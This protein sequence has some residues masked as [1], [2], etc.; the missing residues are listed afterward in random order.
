M[1]KNE[2]FYPFDSF[3]LPEDIL[4][5]LAYYHIPFVS[6]IL[7]GL[8]CNRFYPKVFFSAHSGN[9]LLSLNSV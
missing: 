7:S 4:T 9:S 6:I 2:H 5:N 8:E 1:H 3:V